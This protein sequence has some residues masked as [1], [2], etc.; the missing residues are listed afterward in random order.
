M[1]FMMT[2][3]IGGWTADHRPRKGEKAYMGLDRQLT[4]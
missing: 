3:F 1:K 4:I 2:Q